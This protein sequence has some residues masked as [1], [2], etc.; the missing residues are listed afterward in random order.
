VKAGV[1]PVTARIDIALMTRMPERANA[2]RESSTST[3]ELGLLSYGLTLSLR[4]RARRANAATTKD[5]V[6]KFAGD[7]VAVA[8]AAE[9]VPPRST[10]AVRLPGYPV[11]KRDARHP[12][13]AAG[14]CRGETLRDQIGD[15]P[16]H[17]FATMCSLAT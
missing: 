1:E 17:C 11:V 15:S 12:E 13:R 5:Y 6:D 2:R 16:G 8:R 4:V 9:S 3:R 14:H 10:P 7:G